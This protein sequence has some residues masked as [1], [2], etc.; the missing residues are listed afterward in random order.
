MS[1]FFSV[2]TRSTPVD[3]RKA[4]WSFN[5]WRRQ[6]QPFSIIPSN[7]EKEERERERRKKEG[8]KSPFGAGCLSFQNLYFENY[9]VPP[10][11]KKNSTRVFFFLAAASL[12]VSF[13]LGRGFYWGPKAPRTPFPVAYG[14]TT[15]NTPEPVRFQ[16]LSLVRPS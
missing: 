7:E 11:Q 15:G 10:R 5:F 9:K 8:K 2:Y 12:S 13:I 6:R 3:A 16:K 1:I 14:H 4:C